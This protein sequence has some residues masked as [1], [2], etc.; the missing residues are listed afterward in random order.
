M[1]SRKRFNATDHAVGLLL[2]AF[3]GSRVYKTDELAVV[4]DPMMPKIDARDAK[5]PPIK[6]APKRRRKKKG[7]GGTLW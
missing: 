2:N 4:V 5:K 3:P 6:A 1:T 7:G